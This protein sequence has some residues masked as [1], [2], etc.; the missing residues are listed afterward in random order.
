MTSAILII[1][2]AMHVS[3]SW[4]NSLT[5]KLMVAN[6]VPETY[7]LYNQSMVVN[8]FIIDYFVYEVIT[9]VLLSLIIFI[10][11]IVFLASRLGIAF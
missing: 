11:I 10:S 7:R 4:P 9:Y 3:L 2:S 1:H 5:T 6:I 8:F